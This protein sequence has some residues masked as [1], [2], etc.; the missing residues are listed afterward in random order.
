MQAYRHLF[1][2]INDNFN[3][4]D[5]A[6]L[7]QSLGLDIEELPGGSGKKRKAMELQEYMRRR[8]RTDEL[9]QE[10]HRERPR[11]DLRPFGGSAPKES[12][13]TLE[14]PAQAGRAEI[15]PIPAETPIKPT[16]SARQ[17]ENFD[18]HIGTRREDGRYPLTANSPAGETAG[19]IWQML[20]LEDEAFSDV[21]Y[22]LRELMAKPE[23]AEQFGRQLHTFLFPSPILSLYERSL[24]KVLAEGKKGLRVRLH[25]S[26]ESA[27][28]L[29]QIPWEYC[30]SDR[31]Y[32]AV[33][34]ATPIVRY[35]PTDRPPTP[36]TVP[37]MVRILLVMASPDDQQE[38]DV[39]AEE[40]RI[41]KALAS[42]ETRGQ[43]KVEVLPHATRLKLFES[44][45]TFDPHILHFVGHGE[46]SIAGEGTLI[47]ENEM[48]QTDA[49]DAQWMLVLLQNSNVKLAILNA[50]ETAATE[51]SKAF[52]GVA[53]R[54]VWAGIPAVIAMQVAI[55]DLIAV[56]FMQY[57]YGA[58]AQGKPL[59]MAMTAARKGAY[60]IND[61]VF[62]A[63]PVLFMRAPDG[64]IWHPK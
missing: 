52:M 51:E 32:L 15:Q 50:C 34:E 47:L 39:V 30:A 63:I 53:P 19:S 22:Y 55:P 54:L 38:L 45:N 40:Q 6:F 33:D 62:W 29:S 31:T 61:K 48:S 49:I 27:P 46:L 12:E 20:P 7:C 3:Y 14:D 25:I 64:V 10:V 13:T 5:L 2:L 35:I 43:V 41:R 57:L 4:D 8:G 9:L 28:E 26:L 18:I 42:L 21:V 60:L 56:A 16:L 17:Y 23:D 58:L 36:V 44:F 37:E 1:E 11:L 24:A 59:D